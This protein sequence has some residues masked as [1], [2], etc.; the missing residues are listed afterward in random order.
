MK[1]NV[2]NPNITQLF[3]DCTYYAIQNNNNDFWLLIILGF[4]SIERK[5]KLIFIGLIK[6]ENIE[7]FT[8]IVRCLKEN[9]KF[10]LKFIIC[11]CSS[12]EIMCIRKELPLSKIILC[13]FH[14][15]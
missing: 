10:Q 14:I 7:A 5:S 8:V 6:K 3:M 15:I 9:Y 13:Y 4:D 1:N 2:S 12:A 11:D